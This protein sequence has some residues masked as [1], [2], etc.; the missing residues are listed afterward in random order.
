MESSPPVPPP[1]VSVQELVKDAMSEVPEIYIC[2]D[3]EV[4]ENSYDTIPFISMEKLLSQDKTLSVN[5]LEKLH[6][7]CKDWGIF[8]VRKS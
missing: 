5:E 7:T 1:I 6:S 3:G 8:Q 2:R 4:S